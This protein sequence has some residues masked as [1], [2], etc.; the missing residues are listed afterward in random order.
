MITIEVMCPKK[1]KMVG[2]GVEWGTV[3][4]LPIQTHSNCILSGF[5]FNQFG[6]MCHD[7]ER[8]KITRCIL[9]KSLVF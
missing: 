4:G 3:G 2:V 7:C 5:S 9:S 1:R 8:G 6:I